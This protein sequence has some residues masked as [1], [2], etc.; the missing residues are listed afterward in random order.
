MTM[1]PMFAYAKFGGANKVYYGTCASGEV[2]SY[3][4]HLIANKDAQLAVS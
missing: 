1:M 3:F 2:T 4:T